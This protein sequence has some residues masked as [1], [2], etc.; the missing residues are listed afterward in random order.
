VLFLETYAL[1]IL[2]DG[3]RA[4][5]LE[6]LAY[7]LQSRFDRREPIAGLMDVIRQHALAERAKTAVLLHYYNRGMDGSLPSRSVKAL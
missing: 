4:S 7:D 3:Y 1:G 2:R 5:P 6:D